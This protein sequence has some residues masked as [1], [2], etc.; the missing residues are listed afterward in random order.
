MW[1]PNARTKL[2]QNTRSRNDAWLQL[3]NIIIYLYYSSLV[4]KWGSNSWADIVCLIVIESVISHHK[5]RVKQKFLVLFWVV[6]SV[7]CLPAVLKYSVWRCV[8]RYHKRK[9]LRLSNFNNKNELQGE[10]ILEVTKNE[11]TFCKKHDHP[12]NYYHMGLV[13]YWTVLW[14]VFLSWGPSKQLIHVCLDVLGFPWVSVFDPQN[15]TEILPLL[16]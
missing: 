4:P 3:Q 6:F 14:G 11:S 12:P 5:I 2:V 16:A 7:R 9:S 10:F 15:F 13:M 8:C 1:D